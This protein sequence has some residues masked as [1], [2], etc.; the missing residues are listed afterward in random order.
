[1][2]LNPSPPAS[3]LR[4]AVPVA[5]LAVLLLV[6]A[7]AAVAVTAAYFELRPAPTPAGSIA[8]TDDLGRSVAVP[9]DPARVVV[10]GA[11]IVD[12]MVLL[13]LGEKI[14]GVDCGIPSA[15][16]ISQDYNSTQISQWGLASVACVESYP[17]FDVPDVLN[18]SPDLVLS[19]TLVSVA[20]LEQM[21]TTYGIPVVVLQPSSLGGI[22]VDVALL[23]EIFG[24]A[25]AAQSLEDQLQ[26]VLGT[27]GSAVANLT[28]SLSFSSL[29]TVLLTYDASPA[30][31]PFPGYYTY[32]PGTFGESLL[33]FVGATSISAN[34]TL[35]YPELSG[36]QVLYAD[37]S[38]ILYGTGFGLTLA[39]TYEVAPDWSS[40]PAVS[41]GSAYSVD[42]NFLTEPDP[43]M[44]L[45]GV[46]LLLHILHP[47]LLPPG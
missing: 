28:S 18:A 23:G 25:S 1:M 6:V 30:S 11:S 44:I 19:S 26:Q 35:P 10:I 37:P 8:L 27:V 13:G 39:N 43:T 21:S 5:L 29:P 45:E 3:S 42:S 20:T 40:L 36:P 22:L 7:G 38:I 46:P 16:G 33:E 15:G 34:S 32:G 24:V 12:S 4:R 31:G 9:H 14:V 41:S 47:G 17:S 2:S